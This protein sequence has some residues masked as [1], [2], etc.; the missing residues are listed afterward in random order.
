MTASHKCLIATVLLIASLTNLASAEN[1]VLFLGN[2]FTLGSGGARSVPDIFDALAN[3]A[4]QEDPTTVM[5]AVGGKDYQYH[6]ENHQA[7]IASQQWTH[8]VMQNY[9]TEPT[10]I[11]SVTDHMTYGTLL[12]GSVMANNPDTNVHLYQT[13]AR[14][15]I[16][17][18]ITGTSTATTF[19]STDEML[20]EL[21]T[22]YQALADALN[23]DHPTS[24]PVKVD[25]VGQA[26]D[27]AGGNLHPSDPNYIDLFTD[28]EY[29]GN[30]LGYYLSACVHYAVIYQDSPM[31]LYNTAEIAALSLNL[32]TSEAA[33]VENIAWQTVVTAG[34][35]EDLPDTTPPTWTRLTQ[36]DANTLVL[37]FDDLLDETS[38]LD[39][40]NYTIINRGHRVTIESVVFTG[41]SNSVTLTTATE[42]IG[43]VLVE[44]STGLLDDAGNALADATRMS[45]QV[46]QSSNL[47]Y[48]DFGGASTVSGSTDTWNQVVLDTTIRDAVGNGTGTPAVL[49][50]DLLDAG[51][52]STG[53]S[54]T[55]T[56]TLSGTN[57]S[58]TSSG[59]YPSGATSDSLYGQTGTFS[60]FTDNAQGVFVF[61]NLDPGTAYDFTFYASRTS[62]T[63]NRETEYT[64]TGA[65][66]SSV[67]LDAAN[68]VS[69]TVQIT[70][71]QPNASGNITLTVN[72][73]ANNTNSDGFYYIGVVVID[74][75]ASSPPLLYPPVS[76]GNDFIID[77]T[78]SGELWIS[79]NLSSWTAVT[80]QPTPP[81]EDPLSAEGRRF[82]RIE[83]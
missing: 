28:D 51:G 41:L 52:T 63:D 69:S 27:N 11:G 53:I 36:A 19:E 45:L 20:G 81:Y 76:L 70:N 1:K 9:S 46:A 14:S 13:W 83:Y 29:H 18:L 23:T 33:F 8:V 12:Y 49:L 35:A 15:A 58:G 50:S 5:A 22:N 7:V 3:A 66:S 57:Q 21:V 55:M 75:Q 37:Q 56:D 17:S 25:P 59:P 78:G 60:S 64:L 79:D 24:P 43:N 40:A 68:N 71:L 65:S 26:W 62:A 32:D 42:I 10:H 34:L 44:V 67:T 16:H 31:G 39:P 54:L 6:Y 2:S 73:G 61:S 30:S 4:G 72:K 80:P 82:Y 38:A 47:I 48:L 74:K 77:W